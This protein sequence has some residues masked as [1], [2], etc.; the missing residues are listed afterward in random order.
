MPRYI[1]RFLKDVMGDNGHDRE[2]CQASF[3][4]EAGSQAEASELAKVEFC[5]KERTTDWSLYADRVEAAETEF[6]S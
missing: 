1:V 5:K 3:E 6:P 2:A 4:M